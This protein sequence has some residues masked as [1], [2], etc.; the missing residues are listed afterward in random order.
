MSSSGKLGRSFNYGHFIIP[1]LEDE[2]SQVKSPD[3]R[4]TLK[5]KHSVG[6]DKQFVHIRSFEK[7][8]SSLTI[9]SQTCCS[10]LNPVKLAS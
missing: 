8:E 3:R 9:F 1:N 7:D 2:L 5:K 10:A 4:T 6:A